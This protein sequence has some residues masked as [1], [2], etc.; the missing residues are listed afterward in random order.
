MIASRLRRGFP[1]ALLAAVLLA[2]LSPGTAGAETGA[3]AERVQVLYDAANRSVVRARLRAWDAEPSRNLEFVWEPDSG[4]DPDAAEGTISGRGKLVWRVRGSATYD[5]RTIYSTYVGE[6]AEGRPHGQGR[7][8]RRDGEVFEGEWVEGLLHGQG[9]HLDAAGNRYQGAFENGRPHGHGRQAMADGSIY[10]GGFRNGL[11]DG[12]GTMR[13]PGGT[14]YGSRWQAGAETGGG[15]PDVMADA[16]VG[17]LLRAQS[18]GGDAGKIDL[19]VTVD[20]RITRLA[21]MQ[22]THAVFDE[23]IEIY[24]TDPDM[25]GTWTG[26]K[27]I[28]PGGYD[29]TFGW[30]DWEDAPAFVQVDFKTQDGSRVRLDA[31]ELQVADSQ[32]YRKPFLSVTSH[33]G[34]IGFRPT[35]SLVNNGWGPAS[36]GRLSVEFFNRDDPEQATRTFELDIDDFDEGLDVSLRP[37]LEEAGVDT[38]ALE[39]GRFTCPSEEQ[40]PQCR[41]ELAGEVDFGEVAQLLSGKADVAVGVRG[42]LDYSWADDRGNVY[43]ASEPVEAALQLAAIET[44]MMAAEYG[45]GWGEPPA[46]LRYQE[47]RLPDDDQNYVIDLPVRGNKNLAAYIA[48]LKIYAAHSS[49]HRFRAVARFADGSERQSKPVSLFY[50]LPR[51]TSYFPAQ[52]EEACYLDSGAFVPPELE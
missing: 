20:Q 11:R 40:L 46:A 7:L 44:E 10:E 6:L 26:E 3:W 39:E 45:D 35:F 37:L 14:V 29:D 33:W 27:V 31:L 50:I 36:N 42:R 43:D 22:Y 23:H 51:G 28:A 15:R 16:M 30:L 41:R 49:I 13:L 1:A 32:I 52:P 5:R 9:M 24:P 38:A 2:P 8:E 4:F 21:D 12:E 18:G 17:G 48:R 34:C 25:V 47:I 19:S